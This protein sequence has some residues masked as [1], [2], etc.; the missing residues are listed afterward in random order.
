[1]S[2]LRA[3]VANQVLSRICAFLGLCCPDFYSVR[4]RGFYS[5]FVQIFAQK[6][7]GQDLCLPLFLAIAWQPPSHA[8]L[9]LW[10]LAVPVLEEE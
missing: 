10:A 5:E 8:H 9:P 1:M 4:Q 2:H 3:F 7:G 6:L